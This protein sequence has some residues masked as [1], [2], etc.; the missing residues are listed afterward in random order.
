MIHWKPQRLPLV[1]MAAIC[2]VFLAGD[3]WLISQMVIQECWLLN[4][5]VSCQIWID[6]ASI[7]KGTYPNKYNLK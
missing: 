5:K 3:F 4:N 1:H 2:Q 6:D 7:K